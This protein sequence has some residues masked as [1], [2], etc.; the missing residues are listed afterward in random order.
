MPAM[1]AV[2][3]MGGIEGQSRV[4]LPTMKAVLKRVIPL[5][6]RP[7]FRRFWNRTRYAGFARYCPV[8]SSHLLR[9]VPHGVPEEAEAV[10]P[11]CRCK[12][13]HRLA[14]LYF[15]SNPQLFRPGGL[16]L[17]IAP[18]PELGRRLREWAESNGMAYRCGCITAT[19][20]RYFDI[21][22]LPFAT[23]SIDLIYCCHVLNCMQE[24]RAG[25]RELL[26]VLRAQGTALLQVPAFH[27]GKTTLET[28]SLEDRLRTFYDEGIYRC[29]TDADYV[30][31]LSA[32]G[33]CVRHFRAE[34]FAPAE[35]RRYSLK[36]EV[37]HICTKPCLSA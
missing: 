4:I 33:F 10:C 35:I 31:R 6:L 19:G 2:G 9:F 25:M 28:Y 22:S 27:T 18:E 11:V 17:H 34:G 37:L 15:K 30:H 12:A 5:R 21:Q 26:R 23:G 3:N 32:A 24:D 7:A 8:C 14:C 13:P 16:M 20:D 1:V 36:R 29:Y